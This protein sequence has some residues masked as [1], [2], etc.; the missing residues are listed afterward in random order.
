[1]TNRDLEKEFEEKYNCYGS[2]LYRIAFLYLGNAADAE[3]VLQD[4]FAK[5]LF[6][7]KKFSST[8]HEKAWFI[9][10][11][12]NKCLDL[13]KKASRKNLNIETASAMTENKSD[14]EQD[15]LRNIFALP[16]KYKAAV[17]LY[18]YNGY[19]VEEIARILKTSTSAV[20][21]RLQRGREMLKFELE[22]Y[23][24]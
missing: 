3:D 11:T 23:R 8:E 21:K 5:Y 20:K 19:S 12:Q 17:I 6:T 13:L 16:E 14:L 15:V 22:D 24:V 9:R 1:M 7:K 2:M 18:Y 10:S 4:I